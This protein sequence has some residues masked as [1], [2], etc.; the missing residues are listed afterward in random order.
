MTALLVAVMVLA[1][2]ASDVLMTRAMKQVGAVRDF[3]IAALWRIGGRV[4]R[5]A[6]FMVGIA[7]AALH[8]GAFLW[9]LSYADLSFVIPAAA[10][11]YVASTLGARLFL[12]EQVSE[13]RWSGVVLVFA[14]VA[15][16][17]LP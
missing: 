16:V 10:L 4:L 15:L 13:R 11:V 14:G 3:R 2:A 6:S 17:S 8:F 1:D 12:G 9:L 7:F 5:N